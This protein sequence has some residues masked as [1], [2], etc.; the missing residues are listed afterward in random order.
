MSNLI[1]DVLVVIFVILALVGADQA[2]DLH[3]AVFSVTLFVEKEIFSFQFLYLFAFLSKIRYATGVAGGQTFFWRAKF[4]SNI[5]LQ[6]AKIFYINF[7][8]K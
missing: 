1:S 2:A 3:V 6:A 5:V 4:H 8:Y 7:S